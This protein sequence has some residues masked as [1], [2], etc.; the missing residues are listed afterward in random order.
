MKLIS[1]LFLNS[2]SKKIDKDFVRKNKQFKDFIYDLVRQDYIIK[3]G[4]KLT[5]FK[6]DEVIKFEVDPVYKDITFFAKLYLS[7]LTNNLLI[8]LGRS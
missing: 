1:N 8:K 2:I 3:K 7:I 5:Y 4:V 6:P